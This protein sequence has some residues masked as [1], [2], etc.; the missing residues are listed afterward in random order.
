MNRT[1]HAAFDPRKVETPVHYVAMSGM[2]G[3]LPEVCESHGD[4]QSAVHSIADVVGLGKHKR[5]HLSRDGYVELPPWRYV[6][7][8][9]CDCGNPRD[10]DDLDAP[11]NGG[12]RKEQAS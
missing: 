1:P 10:H 11:W 12:G 4:R 9:E 7:V 8:I 5:A 6:E 2:H 3:C